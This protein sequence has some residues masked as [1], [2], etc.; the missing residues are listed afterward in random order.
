MPRG[1]TQRSQ[2]YTLP[3]NPDKAMQEMMNTIDALRSVYME[4]TQALEA[5][6]TNTFLDLQDRK[7][8]S[9]RLYQRGIEEI[10]ARK[11]EMRGADPALKKRLEGMQA[12][13]S[14]LAA[15]NMKALKRMQKTM[16]RLGDRVRSAAKDAVNKQRATSYG[17][18]GALHSHEGRLLSTGISETA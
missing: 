13:F 5:S 1:E 2:D 11:D 6:D 9:A 7:F 3:A 15:T 16:N 10:L 14:D 4:E 12:D 8:E 18:S 17:E